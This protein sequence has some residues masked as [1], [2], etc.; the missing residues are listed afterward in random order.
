[1]TPASTPLLIIKDHHIPHGYLH[2]N[3]LFIINFGVFVKFFLHRIIKL[4]QISFMEFMHRSDEKWPRYHRLLVFKELPSEHF[5]RRFLHVLEF[6]THN[7]LNPLANCECVNAKFKLFDGLLNSC[8]IKNHWSILQTKLIRASVSIS[9][10]PFIISISAK[11]K[12]K[13]SY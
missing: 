11:P 9:G 2:R 13:R 4:S 7:L 12:V 3:W 10:W 1:M 8:V 6:L 5:T